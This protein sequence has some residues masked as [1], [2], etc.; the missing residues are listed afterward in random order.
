MPRVLCLLM[1]FSSFAVCQPFNHQDN[2]SSPSSPVEVVYAIDGSTLTTYNVDQQTFQA[3]AVGSTT[4][5]RSKYPGTGTSSPNG[6]FLYYLANSGSSEEK[7]FVYDTDATGVPGNSPVQAMGASQ[8]LELAVN[9]A[10]TFF[11]TVAVGPVGQQLTR[12]YSIVRNVVDPTTGALSQP[13]TEATYE[14]DSDVSGDDCGLEVLGFNPAGTTMYDAIQ[15]SSPHASGSETFNQRSVD[16]ETGALGSDQ[17]V[18][19]FGYYAASGF[20]DVQF[21]NNLMFAFV[22]YYN[23][24]PNEDTV[25]VYQTQPLN[26]TPVVNCTTTMLAVCGDFS[27]TLAHPSGEYVFMV[28]SNEVTEIGQVDLNAQEIVE[29]NSI[30]FG[31]RQLSPDG[32]VVYG[33]APP[34]ARKIYISGFNAANAEVKLGGT[35]VLPNS[36]D[37]WFTSVRY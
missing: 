16:P 27:A 32:K 29:V 35:I 26:T 28:D 18:Y 7:L 20:A 15:C 13:V 33:T 25:D 37:S 2:A 31:I 14:L 8:L 22:G 3:T 4:L 36:L 6:E 1:C 17:Q 24:G 23:Y 21:E 34:N 5:P 12:Q 11:Y 10:G 30:P 19:E 9:P